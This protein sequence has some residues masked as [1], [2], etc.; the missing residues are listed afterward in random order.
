[1]RFIKDEIAPY[2]VSCLGQLILHVTA[3]HLD[4]FEAEK[5][6]YCG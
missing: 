1:M 2:I 6:S 3:I 5:L 4:K